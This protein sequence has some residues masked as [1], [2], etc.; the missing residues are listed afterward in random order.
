MVFYEQYGKTLVCLALIMIAIAGG[1][2]SSGSTAGSST[3]SPDAADDGGFH[4]S[5]AELAGT[6]VSTDDPAS[7]ISLD[8]TGAARVVTG[9]N[10]YDTSIYMENDVLRLADGTSIGP[11]PIQDGTLIYQGVKYQKQS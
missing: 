9:S 2:T 10:S 11:Y 5:F 3:G 6:Y 4:S 1:C 8:P 7:S